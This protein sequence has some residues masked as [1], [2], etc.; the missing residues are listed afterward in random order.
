MTMKI[1]KSD[2]KKIV[3]ECLVEILNE[4]IMARAGQQSLKETFVTIEDDEVS[5][6][7]LQEGNPG[8]IRKTHPSAHQTGTPNR[9]V[10][11]NK[12]NSNPPMA[13]KNIP[14][15]QTNL[16]PELATNINQIAGGNSILQSILADTASTTLQEQNMNGHNNNPSAGGG[17]GSVGV[18]TDR[19]SMIVQNSDPISIFGE[20]MAS[21]WA[22][23]A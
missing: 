14:T 5:V 12:S 8:F 3:K 4:G 15:K 6:K 13:K 9:Q 22:T 18:P 2:I 1:K 7:N 19:A 20:E 21:R 17:M 10:Q 16:P 23:A 11:N